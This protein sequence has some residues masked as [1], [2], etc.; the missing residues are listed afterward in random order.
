MMASPLF[1]LA[2]L[3]ATRKPVRTALTAGTVLAATALLIIATSWLT[4]IWN[5]VLQLTTDLAG[6][7]RIV[8]PGYEEREA[9]MPLFENI[10]DVDPV[11]TAI[12]NV[13]GVEEVY[14]I[15]ESGVTVTVGEEIGDVFG[16]AVGAPLAFFRDRQ[17]VT[18]KLVEGRFWEEGKEGEIVLGA[19]VAKLAGAKVG[20][21][22]VVLGQT[23]DGSLSPIKGTLVGIA[24]AGNPSVDMKVFL[25]L[26]VTRYMADMDGGALS[27]LAYGSRYQDVAAIS[28]AIRGLPATQ[29]LSVK[30][31]NERDPF[32][33]V[34][35]TT[36]VVR[37]LLTSII[38]LLASLGVWNTMMMSV[39]E[40]TAE[41]GV[42]RAMGLTRLGA[43]ALFV[44]EALTIAIL[45]GL[46]GVVLGS[47]PTLYMERHGIHLSEKI[48]ASTGD[49]PL[50]SVLRPYL[51]LDVILFAFALGLTMALI[52][53][54]FPALRAASVQPH[55][56]MTRN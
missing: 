37:G 6:H 2:V 34:V 12:T 4:G 55:T 10:A 18:E 16:L 40:R 7:V 20:Q 13:P 23:Q 30:A 8:T 29:G 21:E 42:L 24:R 38:V 9:T 27:V 43:V 56:A 17:K 47:L 49:L 1:R 3:G 35:A 48:T 46:G 25:P 26:S 36:R 41:I 32:R 28:S 22:V 14:P 45:G 51:T 44:G 50:V 11:V 15:I 19:T 31:W 33:G 5:E 54:F 52:G 53:S 39:L